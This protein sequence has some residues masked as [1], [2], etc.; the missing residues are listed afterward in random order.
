MSEISLINSEE[1]AR[2]WFEKKKKL[3]PRGVELCMGWFNEWVRIHGAHNRPFV[4][5]VY[6]YHYDDVL[7]FAKIGRPD[8]YFSYAL[9]NEKFVLDIDTNRRDFMILNFRGNVHKPADAD[10]E[11]IKTQIF[12]FFA[13]EDDLGFPM[14]FMEKDKTTFEITG[15]EK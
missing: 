10:I 7:F 15:V 9:M 5:Y 4:E 12:K 3:N 13:V 8:P 2:V 14:T 1:E 11:A 6:I